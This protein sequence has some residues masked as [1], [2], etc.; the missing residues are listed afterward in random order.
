MTVLAVRGLTKHFA[1]VPALRGVDLDVEEGS[2]H[3][4]LGGNGC[5]KSTLIKALAGVGPGDDGEIAVAGQLHAAPAMTPRHAREAGLR[6]VHQQLSIFPDLSVAENLAIGH[7]WEAGRT[8]RIHWRS[9][10]RR[11]RDL[12]DRFGVPVYPRQLAGASSVATQTMICI[13]RAMQDLE[14]AG[15]LVLDEPTSSFPPAQ[16]DQLLAFVRE[17]VG[18]GHSVVY[19]THRLDEVVR[20]ADRATIMRDGLVDVHVERDEL[21]HDR[22][23]RAIIGPAV[24][25]AGTSVS[26][27]RE[28]PAGPA[29]VV[30]DGLAG[31]P[32]VGASFAL[33]PGEIVGLAGLLGSGRSSLLKLLF[34]ALPA[35]AGTVEIDGRPFRPAGPGAAMRAGV[36]YI[37]EDRQAD[38]AF[39]SLSVGE[40]LSLATSGE[41]FRRGRIRH[42]AEAAAARRL[43]GDYHVKTTSTRAAMGTL[44]GGNQQKVVLARWLRRDPRLLL[45]DEPSQGVDVGARAEI[46][47]LV[48][49]AVDQGATAL[50][51]TSDLDELATFCDRAL[52]IRSGRIADE[53]APA[54]MS[55]HTLQSRAFGIDQ[56]AS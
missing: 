36:A 7:G 42:R 31:G 45:L 5:G 44:S 52:V 12:L 4:L 38:A 40:N 16:V 55:E 2:V 11:A 26:A 15:V 3:A 10:N 25:S 28:P 24:R 37:P 32:V 41:Y 47:H 17:F 8:G 9:Q 33:R 19:V 35:T 39:A 6:F 27:R 29:S 53:V 46:W 23:S 34:G 14:Q 56:E 18:H 49:H 50:V 30:V 54:D 43:V 13:A 21:T 51:A 48:R 22:L 20:V 1:G